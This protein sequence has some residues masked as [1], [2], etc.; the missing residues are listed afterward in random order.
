MANRWGNSG[1]SDRLYFWELQNCCRW[2]LQPWNEKMFAPWKKSYDQ[3]RQHI[4]KQRHYFANKISSSQSYGFSSSHVWMWDLDYKE[5]WAAK[6][7]CFS[8]MV[9]R[10]LLTVSW[11]A[12]R[13]NQSILIFRK[14]VLDIHWKDW[15]WRWNSNTLASWCKELTHLKMPWC[16]ERLKAGEEDDR[17]WDNHLDGYLDEKDRRREKRTTE[18]EIT[19]WMPSGWHHQISGHEFEYARDRE[20]WHVQS[21]RMQRVRHDW[22]TELNYDSDNSHL[23]I[24]KLLSTTAILVIWLWLVSVLLGQYWGQRGQ[25]GEYSFKPRD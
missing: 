12:R 21:M 10:R 20:A 22:A 23:D 14:S 4:K 8:T 5:S 18:D 7:W 9:W 3:P 11:T 17:G 16:W 6:N 2:W 1:N 15:C 25:E 13:S 19:I 24:L